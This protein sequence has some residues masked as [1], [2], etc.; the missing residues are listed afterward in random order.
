[1]GVM[2]IA[3]SMRMIRKRRGK[4]VLVNSDPTEAITKIKG[5]EREV[6]LETLQK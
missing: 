3:L 2:L 1:M 5:K 6:P 4:S